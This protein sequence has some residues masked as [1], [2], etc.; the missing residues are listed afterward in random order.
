M[1]KSIKQK[2]AERLE[3]MKKM[4]RGLKI[5]YIILGVLVMFS[6]IRAVMLGNYENAFLCVLVF[7]MFSIPSFVKR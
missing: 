6:L 3:E 7:L 2:K 4:S 1:R 5:T